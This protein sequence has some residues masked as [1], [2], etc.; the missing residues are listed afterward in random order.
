MKPRDNLIEGVKILDPF[1][2]KNRFRFSFNKTGSSSG[3]EYAFGKY[4]KG[5]KVI[6]LHYRYSLGLVSYSINNIQLS[7][8]DY[9]KLLGV[10]QNHYP[11]F[12]NNPLQAFRD[13]LYDL[14]NYAVDFISGPGSEFQVL[15]EKLRQDPGMF[16]G[17]KGLTKLSKIN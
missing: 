13:L 15:A 14:E 4:S 7:H 16:Q 17:F 1:L 2:R 12:S 5:D 9:M 10:S 3:G 11:G 8:V 6:E